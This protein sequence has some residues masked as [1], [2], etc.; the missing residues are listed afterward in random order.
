M[1]DVQQQ[2]EGA[3]QAV[4]EQ[5]VAERQLA[6]AITDQFL[7][8]YIEA[9]SGPHSDTLMERYYRQDPGSGASVEV[10][11]VGETSAFAYLTDSVGLRGLRFTD[12]TGS[13]VSAILYGGKLFCSDPDTGLS[14]AP[15]KAPELLSIW[16]QVHEARGTGSR[17]WGFGTGVEH[18]IRK[19]RL[20][21]VARSI[22]AQC[23][24]KVTRWMEDD[25]R[26]HN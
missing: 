1:S 3:R 5:R 12:A 23:R 6:D 8:D 11:T 22:V 19:D 13:T 10:K 24:I 14:S 21:K 17:S 18:K 20:G 9:N 15:E 2:V 7:G 4:A 16:E 25:P 26:Y